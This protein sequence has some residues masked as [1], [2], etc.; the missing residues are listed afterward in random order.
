[1]THQRQSDLEWLEWL[2]DIL[3]TVI[4]AAALL[5]FLFLVERIAALVG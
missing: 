5:A 4:V 1:M 2:A 3:G